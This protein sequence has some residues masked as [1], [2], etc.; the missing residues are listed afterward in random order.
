MQEHGTLWC[1]NVTVIHHT[2]IRF[3]NQSIACTLSTMESTMNIIYY[4]LLILSLQVPRR[5]GSPRRKYRDSYKRLRIISKTTTSSRRPC[6]TR[7]FSNAILATPE[8]SKAWRR[9]TTTKA[10]I[11]GY[12]T[13]AVVVA[14][15]GSCRR[16][17]DYPDIKASAVLW[18]RK[19]CQ[20]R[21][22][23][24]EVPKMKIVLHFVCKSSTFFT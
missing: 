11:G 18:A 24:G 10:W 19:S 14:A 9:C 15:A 3:S 6:V 21:W 8:H 23:A 22:S 4:M 7:R 1:Q 13:A 5:P 20:V 16:S 17:R 2:R 12:Q